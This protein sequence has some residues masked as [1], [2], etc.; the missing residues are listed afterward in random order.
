MEMEEDGDTDETVALLR[1]HQNYRQ[2]QEMV[3]DCDDPLDGFD[4]GLLSD[5]FVDL[6]ELSTLSDGDLCLSRQ[7]ATTIGMEQQKQRK[8]NG[9]QMPNNGWEN[10]ELSNSFIH[11]NKSR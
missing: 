7:L 1:L 9:G 4:D 8:E 10:A 11:S 6:Q 3:T 2:M 5:E